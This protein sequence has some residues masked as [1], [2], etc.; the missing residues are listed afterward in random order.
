MRDLLGRIAALVWRRP[1]AALDREGATEAPSSFP[2]E[3]YK[4]ALDRLVETAFEAGGREE[5]ARLAAIMRLPGAERFPRLAWGLAVS[6]VISPTEAFRAFAAAELDAL[7]R[8][9]PTELHSTESDGRI[10]H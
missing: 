9:Q 8:Q 5:R 2:A 6:G 7:A 4:L 3:A 10:L 1:P